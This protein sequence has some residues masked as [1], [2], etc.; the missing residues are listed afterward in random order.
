[1]RKLFPPPDLA[2]GRHDPAHV[3]RCRWQP[4]PQ[5]PQPYVDS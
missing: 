3:P 1:M 2:A 5:P 4:E